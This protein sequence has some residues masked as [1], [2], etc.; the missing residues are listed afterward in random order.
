MG[1]A[2]ASG[3]S[4]LML[5]RVLDAEYHFDPAPAAVAVI[6]TAVLAN[7][8]GWLSS[9]RILGKKPLEVLRSE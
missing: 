2:L 9:L 5:E 3:F 6:A 1:A 8:A 4:N 7:L